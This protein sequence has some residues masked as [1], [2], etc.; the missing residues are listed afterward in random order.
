MQLQSRI[1]KPCVLNRIVIKENEISWE[2]IASEMLQMT[3]RKVEKD[4]E[5]R[6]HSKIVNKHKHTY[7]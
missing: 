1:F 3:K 4:K 7:I 2:N 6:L 5:E